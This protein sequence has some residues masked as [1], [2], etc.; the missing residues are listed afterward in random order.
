M[1]RV[2]VRGIQKNCA[3]ADEALQ[4]GVLHLG[5]AE[6]HVAAVHVAA[7]PA[8]QLEQELHGSGA[9]IGVH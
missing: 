2:A 8:R 3:S 4:V 7:P 5:L 1:P 6:A 9:M